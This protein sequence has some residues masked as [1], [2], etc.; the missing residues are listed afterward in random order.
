MFCQNFRKEV[1]DE[2][3]CQKVFEKMNKTER[4]HCVQ[5]KGREL[6]SRQISDHMICLFLYEE[7]IDLTGLF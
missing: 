6:I 3:L 2:E 7:E 4:Y 1:H 5:K